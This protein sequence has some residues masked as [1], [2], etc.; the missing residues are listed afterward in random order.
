VSLA[1]PPEHLQSLSGLEGRR[2]T[3]IDRTVPLVVLG[4]TKTGLSFQEKTSTVSFNLHGCRYASRHEYPVGSPVGLRVLQPDGETIS[5]VIRA[6][7]KSIHPPASPRE[8]FQVGVELESPANIWNVSPPPSDWNR[9][10]GGSVAAG[11]ATAT[12]PAIEPSEPAAAPAGFSAASEF[13][14]GEA[15]SSQVTEFPFPSPVGA[16]AQPAKE[17]SPSKPERVAITID[18][19]VAAMQG[20]LQAAAEKVVQNALANSLDEAIHSA[21]ARA[22]GVRERNLQQWGEFS[23]QRLESLMRSSREEVL[24]HL[25]SR[26]GEVQ[27][28]WEEQHNA[29]RAQAEEIV[30]RLEKLAADTQ[31]NLAETEKFIVK[32]TH[33]IEPQ[34]RGRLY[35]SLGQATEQFEA[36]ADRISDRQLVRVMEA[37][38]MVT[39]EAAAQLDARVA[40]SRALLHSAAGSTLDEFRRQAEVQVDLSISETTE[41]V[42]SALSALDAENRVACENRRRTMI[43]DLTRTTEQST[44]QFRSGIKAFLYSCLGAAVGAVDEHAKTTLDGLVKDP[45]SARTIGDITDISDMTKISPDDEKPN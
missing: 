32:A 15:R 33:E 44:E 21:L 38:R 20:K 35:E 6:F 42:R 26:L 17:A 3:R 41:R 1:A 22:E 27:S 19:L 31:R 2:S 7:V 9:L 30:Q 12:V 29:F 45:G 11:M 37:T 24:G 23:E 40:E 34:T 5:P 16:S 39:R 14:L 4:Q 13:S 36:A 25:E 43:D 8:L 18:Q 28:R 10:L